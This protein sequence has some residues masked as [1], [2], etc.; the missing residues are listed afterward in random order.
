MLKIWANTASYLYLRDLHNQEMADLYS[1]WETQIEEHSIPR[2]NVL[3][4]EKLLPCFNNLALVKLESVDESVLSTGLDGRYAMVGA[5]L[6][7]LLGKDPTGQWLSE[8]YSK[9]LAEE[10]SSCFQKAVSQR[11]ALYYRREFR[12][13]RKHFGY[14]RLVLP[15]RGKTQDIT[16]V[17]LCIYP[18]DQSLRDAKQWQKDI[19]QAEART[20][21]DEADKRAWAEHLKME[22]HTDLRRGMGLPKL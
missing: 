14:Y 7:R 15:L 22:D 2:Q 11:Q 18:M 20:R 17:L 9:T 21:Q 8:V 16:S 3:E 1:Y 6:K 12:I 13:L 5:N 10:I 4:P 19:R